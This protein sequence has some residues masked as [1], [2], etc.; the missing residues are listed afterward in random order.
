MSSPRERGRS[1]TTSA[2]GDQLST[3]TSQSCRYTRAHTNKLY[4]VGGAVADPGGDPRVPRIPP[5]SL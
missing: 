3:S 1:A 4:C 2:R 5:F